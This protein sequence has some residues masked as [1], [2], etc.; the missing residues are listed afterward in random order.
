MKLIL[1]LLCFS[2]TATTLFAQSKKDK[3]IS[4]SKEAKAEFIKTDA[5]MANL[6]GKAYGYV[7]LP[8][9]GKGAIGVGAL[10]ATGLLMNAARLS[11]P[12]R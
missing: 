8:N 9:V 3:L 6:F 2:I 7:I 11:A 4:D 5:K 10:R 12:P 1:G